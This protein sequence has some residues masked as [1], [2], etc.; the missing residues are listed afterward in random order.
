MGKP[1]RILDLSECRD[2]TEASTETLAFLMENGPNLSDRDAEMFHQTMTAWMRDFPERSPES[3]AEVQSAIAA[4]HAAAIE[5]GAAAAFA[6]MLADGTVVQDAATG[7]YDL[8]QLEKELRE[9]GVS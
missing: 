2:L 3:D 7:K 5:R 1:Q 6:Q 9:L 8:S 4:G